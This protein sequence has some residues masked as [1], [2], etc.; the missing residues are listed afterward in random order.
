MSAFFD[1]LAAARGYYT[2]HS[3]QLR[4]LAR[5]VAARSNVCPWCKVS[6]ERCQPCLDDEENGYDD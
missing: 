6:G 2:V 3:F 1:E 4:N 5:H